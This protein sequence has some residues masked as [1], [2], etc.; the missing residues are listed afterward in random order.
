MGMIGHSPDCDQY[1]KSRDI[2]KIRAVNSEKRK[3]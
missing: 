1:S 2:D 3:K